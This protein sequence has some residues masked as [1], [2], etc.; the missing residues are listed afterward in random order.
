MKGEG[1]EEESGAGSGILPKHVVDLRYF[2]SPQAS[3]ALESYDTSGVKRVV[4]FAPGRERDIV[5][6]YAGR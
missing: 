4:E 2:E 6:T 1:H 3:E 5:T